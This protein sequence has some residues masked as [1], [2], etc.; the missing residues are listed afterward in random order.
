MISKQQ[1][2]HNIIAWKASIIRRRKEHKARKRKIEAVE[3]ALDRRQV[4]DVSWMFSAV[5]QAFDRLSRKPKQVQGHYLSAPE[6]DARI[7]KTVN[8]KNA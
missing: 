8:K 2:R 1:Q 5:Q 6:I 4:P 3:R 7:L